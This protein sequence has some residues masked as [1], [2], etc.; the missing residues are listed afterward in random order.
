MWKEYLDPLADQGYTLMSPACTNGPSGIAWY[1]SFFAGC[2]GCRI[3]AMAVHYYGTDATQMINYLIELHNT[4]NRPIWVTEFAC[5]DFSYRT[6]CPS[7]YEFL[8]TVKKFMDNTDWVEA[9]FAFGTIRHNVITLHHTNLGQVS[10]TTCI[11]LILPT[12][13][14]VLMGIRPPSAGNTLTNTLLP[15][16]YH[17]DIPGKFNMITS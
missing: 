14:L 12:N 3:H 17:I 11:M 13:F 8:S 6:K 5:Q 10:W 4:F 15:R 2:T 1:K 9:Y 16:L 7:A